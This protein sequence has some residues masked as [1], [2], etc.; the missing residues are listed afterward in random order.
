MILSDRNSTLALL[1]PTGSNVET[2]SGCSASNTNCTW[3][4]SQGELTSDD[5][6]K[7]TLGL[8]AFQGATNLAFVGLTAACS[9]G[10]PDCVFSGLFGRDH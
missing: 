3:T 1:A 2:V 8:N 10:N 7:G 5:T 4:W 9:S 6:T